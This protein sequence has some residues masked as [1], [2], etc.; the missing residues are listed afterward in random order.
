MLVLDNII[1]TCSDPGLGIV[2][3]VLK[4]II[5]IVQIVGPIVFLI[6]LAVNFTKLMMNPDEKKL[7]KN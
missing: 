6:A 3:S 4:R 7:L 2:L 5:N 1:S